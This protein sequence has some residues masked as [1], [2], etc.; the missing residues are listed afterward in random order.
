MTVL[1]YILDG[2]EDALALE[3]ELG[4]RSFECARSLLLP[5]EPAAP[6]PALHAAT[7]P[8]A[9]L[10]ARPVK[11]AE[12]ASPSAKA[13]ESFVF[14]HDSPLSAKGGAMVSKIL[15][16]LKAAHPGIVSGEEPVCCGGTLPK[17][18]VY[19]V[20]G[21]GALRKWFPDLK[22][23]PG[24]WI[25]A[26]SGADVLVTYSPEYIL[27][28]G[29]VTPAVQKI[30]KEMWTSLKAVPQRVSQFTSK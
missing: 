1:D 9:P 5:V 29:E 6:A 28:F 8:L 3:R 21:A 17:S 18:G 7:P 27:R 14:L 11:P 30:K 2:F 25:K 13:A 20:L 4:V 26:A 16:A 23:S 10:P 24:M 19:V 15:D 12:P 22:A